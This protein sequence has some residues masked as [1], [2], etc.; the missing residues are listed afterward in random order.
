MATTPDDKKHDP[1]LDIAERVGET[2]GNIVNEIKALDER[3]SELMDRLQSL[4]SN[5]LQKFDSVLP[6]ALDRAGDT[7]KDTAKRVRREPCGICKFRTDPPHDARLKAHRDQGD[8]K[9]ALTDQELA[10]LHLRR[11][12]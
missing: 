7:L 1:A 8:N 10:E 2:I 6:A 5:L 9:Q 11:V 12:D 3:K 4:R